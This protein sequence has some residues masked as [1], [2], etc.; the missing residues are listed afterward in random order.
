MAK[1]YG[2]VAG[3]RP[4]EKSANTVAELK[5]QMAVNGD[6]TALINGSPAADSQTLKDYDIVTFAAKVKGA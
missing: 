5:S 6:H 3:G 4:L 1:V 2:Q